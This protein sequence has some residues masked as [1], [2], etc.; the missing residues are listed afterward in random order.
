MAGKLK[1]RKTETID[2]KKADLSTMTVG[3]IFSELVRCGGGGGGDGGSPS[4][5]LLFL[6]LALHPSPLSLYLD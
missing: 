4:P 2:E 1:A 5:S 6:F 3:D